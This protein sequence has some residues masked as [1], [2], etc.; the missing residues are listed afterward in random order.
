MLNFIQLSGKFYTSSNRF[1]KSG[2]D[3]VLTAVPPADVD[4][5]EEEEDEADAV[6][7][8]A[9]AAAAAELACCCFVFCDVSFSF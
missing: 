1:C 9:A 8:D 6:V 3:F 4:G 2:I 7:A 5:A